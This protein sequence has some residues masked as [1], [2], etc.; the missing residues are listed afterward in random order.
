MFSKKKTVKVFFLYLKSI[1]E[2]HVINY[3]HIFAYYDT[4]KV[5]WKQKNIFACTKLYTEKKNCLNKFCCCI[6]SH[7][8]PKI[9]LTIFKS[10]FF[11]VYDYFCEECMN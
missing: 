2:C 7:F 8:T 3:F 4:N 10:S 6:I 5:Y 11:S 1:D 9:T